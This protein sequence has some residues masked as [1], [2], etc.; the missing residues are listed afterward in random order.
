[1]P[2]L[3]LAASVGGGNAAC[4][5]APPLSPAAVAPTSNPARADAELANAVLARPDLAAYHG[6][7]EYLSFQA[8]QGASRAEAAAQ[9]D[10]WSSR[11]LANPA[12]IEEL[13][14]VQEWAYLSPADGSGQPFRISIPASYD[15][16]RA[17]PLSV[18][19][20]GVGANHVEFPQVPEQLTAWSADADFIEVAVLGRARGAG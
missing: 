11:V 7:I 20:H 9:R 12:L 17:L 1:M 3:L 18:Y 13:R 6:W 14:G 4:S 10:S 19:L 16:T 8:E 5:A 2:A 15:G